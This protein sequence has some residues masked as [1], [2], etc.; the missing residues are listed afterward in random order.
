MIDFWI[1]KS[2]QLSESVKTLNQE[3]NQIKKEKHLMDAFEQSINYSSRLEEREKVAQKLHDTLGHV[4]TGSTMQL[5]AALIVNETK[6]EQSVEMIQS[7]ID[8]LRNGSDAIRQ[9]L[10]DIQPEKAQVNMAQLTKLIKETEKQTNI[11]FTL[12]YDHLVESITYYQWQM[13]YINIQEAITNMIKY[14]S[15]SECTISFEHLSEH[16]KV[17]CKDNG[18][19][20]PQVKMNMGLKGMSRRLAEI[21]GKLIV[22]GNDGFSIIMLI[23]RERKQNV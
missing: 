7:T 5:E 17:T 12:N 21:N 16:V 14:A 6:P 1:N 22:D 9:I 8:H 4:L 10:K 2:N 3:M 20:T 23:P 15:A 13:I 11:K 18:V 19:G